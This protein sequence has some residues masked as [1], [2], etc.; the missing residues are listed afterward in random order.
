MSSNAYKLDYDYP[1]KPHI[2]DFFKVGSKTQ[3]KKKPQVIELHIEYNYDSAQNRTR[4]KYR[5]RYFDTEMGRFISRD[6]LGYVDGFGLYNGYFAEEF[7]LDPYGEK[8][9]NFW[10]WYNKGCKKK[11][12]ASEIASDTAGYKKCIKDAEE[13]IGNEVIDLDDNF[14]ARMDA[15]DDLEKDGHKEC[16]SRYDKNDWFYWEKVKFCKGVVSTGTEELRIGSRTQYYAALAALRVDLALM[17]AD[18]KDNFP[19]AS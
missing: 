11:C 4:A 15:L 7:K 6:P 13:F 10:Y 19:C 17:K 3:Q 18:C 5:A 2:G 8:S 9:F 16:E 1:R 14:N 12:T